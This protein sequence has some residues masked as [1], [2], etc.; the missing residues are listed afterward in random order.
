MKS[1]I[2][3]LLITHDRPYLLPKVLN[4]LIKFTDLDEFEIWILD[5]ASKPSTKRIISAYSEKYTFLNVFSQ[6]VNQVSVIQN[7][8]IS[9]LKRDLYIKLDDDIFVT[10]NWYSSFINVYERNK[11][12]ISIG[13]VIIPINGFGWK[14]FLEIMNYKEEFN[15]KFKGIKL[16]QGCTEPAVWNNDKVCEF[17]WNKCIPL[18]HTTEKFLKM[19]NNNFIDF[20]VPHRYSIGAI[21]FS[22][23]FWEKMGGW[24]VDEGFN[25]RLKRFRFLTKI[26]Q[27]IA[28]IRNKEEQKRIQEI[29]KIISKIDISGLGVDEEY[30]F[31]FSKENGFKQYVTTEGIVY[32]FS[33]FSTEDYLM[34]KIYLS[35]G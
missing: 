33:F 9:K 6:E 10:E 28:N 25:R 27:F 8:I 2:P 4:R 14:S 5:N 7:S 35:L 22:H 13:S 12:D 29:I 16:V 23:E 15:S 21:V 19:Q 34:K 18:E 11:E 31:K 26:N 30:L 3:I 17:I 24:K 20:I 32:H 1:K